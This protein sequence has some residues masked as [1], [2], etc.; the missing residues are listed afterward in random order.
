M[1]TSSTLE[2]QTPSTGIRMT[3]S[4]IEHIKDMRD[5]QS[6]DLALR[7]GIRQG[8]CSG[9]SYLLTFEDSSGIQSDD[10]IFTLNGLKVICDPKSLS[11]ID[12]LIMDYNHSVIGLGGEFQF[13]NPQATQ[14][15]CCGQSFSNDEIA[16]EN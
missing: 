16:E 1:T 10:K 5:K 2:T 7:V 3:P 15:C 14:T 13:V 11:V 8:G 6:S 12:G 4:A 9:M